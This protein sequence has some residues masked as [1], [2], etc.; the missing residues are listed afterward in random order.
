M[1][2]PA[3]ARS[4]ART[5]SCAGTDPGAHCTA[6]AGANDLAIV[7]AGYDDRNARRI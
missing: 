6:A 4:R 3:F 7:G 2:F 5:E 1:R